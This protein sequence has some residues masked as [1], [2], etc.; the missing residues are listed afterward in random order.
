MALYLKYRPAAFADVV[1]QDHIVTTLERAIE[2]GQTAHA[3]LFSGTRGT[4]KT[5]VARILAKAILVKGTED[6]TIRS[7]IEKG[8]H[9]GSLV[10]LIEIDAA[11]NRRI[12]DVRELIEKIGFSPSVSKA[13]VYI[14]DEVHMLTKEAFNALLKTLE[15]PPEYA[16]FIL[17]TTELHKVPE[18][19]QSRCQRF[20]FKRV[21]DED[22]VRRLQ[23]ITDAE[24]IAVDREALRAI[25]RHASGSF[26]DGIA[27]LDQLRSLPKITLTDVTDRIG[28]TSTQF[29]EDIVSA[30]GKKE[31]DTIAKVVREIE[32]ANVPAE[33]IAGD[34]LGLIRE[35][36]H[37]A[38]EK[39]E[40]VHEFL[41][42]TDTL[43]KALRD[44]R[45]SPVPA[46]VLESALVRLCGQLH[47]TE[48]TK[49]MTAAKLKTRKAEQKK[50]EKMETKK[51]ETVETELTLVEAD[52]LTTENVQKHWN[53][54]LKAVSVPSVRM[55]LKDATVGNVENDTVNLIF[56][57]S[58][59]K[60]KVAETSASR[61]VEETLG[62]L[63]RR[64]VHIRCVLERDIKRAIPGPETDLVEAAEEVFG[65]L[66]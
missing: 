13:K 54:L 59:H 4:G 26:R 49:P 18:T 61:S 41:A 30:I 42:M 32:Q 60:D 21:K 23:F 43:L 10:D 45:S 2:S 33:T 34:L 22:I 25:A 19:I 40:P 6:E 36:M 47:D 38:I 39:R 65:S 57:S 8:V 9:D 55:S 12:D 28:R 20:L 52:D 44:L 5:S 11:S 58:F 31:I 46:L 50:E 37:T 62:A 24:R 66:Q 15:E 48:E 16:F 64:P 3:Y 29:I 63:L 56:G 53:A 1:G 7:H 35:H 27:L 51:E 17:A 14:I